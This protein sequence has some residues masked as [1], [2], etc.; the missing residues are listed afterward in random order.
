MLQSFGDEV[1]YRGPG[2]KAT[3]HTDIELGLNLF[4]DKFFQ[5]FFF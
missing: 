3:A 5:A 2:E 4:I 1:R